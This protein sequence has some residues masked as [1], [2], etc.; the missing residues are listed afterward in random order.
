MDLFTIKENS[1]KTVYHGTDE[2][3][4]KIRDSPFWL[5]HTE[6]NAKSYGNNVFIYKVTKDIK[7]IDISHHVFHQDFMNK[8]NKSTAPEISD[9]KLYPLLALG[10]P[11]FK[12]QIY[13]IGYKSD[14]FYPDNANNNKTFNRR[15]FDL[16]ERF[17]PLFSEK[18]RLSV[19]GEISTD[20]IMVQSLQKL[21]PEFDGYICNN[22]W[23]S[24]HHGGFLVPETCLFRPLNVLELVSFKGGKTTTKQKKS[25]K[26]SKYKGGEAH[27]KPGY[28]PNIF[29]GQ[30]FS[31]DDFCKDTGIPFESM[32]RT[33][34]RE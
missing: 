29:G 5:A 3:M 27:Q 10:L 30:S 24:Y 1:G 8:V 32:V 31:M 15:V 16:I 33:A 19:Q 6:K 25:N 17:V 14:G 20:K 23:P 12:T 21:Y 26:K 22:Y 28:R 4:M 7:L 13:I 9:A 18:H 34:I 11:N 2:P